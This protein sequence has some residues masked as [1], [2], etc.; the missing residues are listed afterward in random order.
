V[1]RVL[2]AVLFAVSLVTPAWAQRAPLSQGP[3]RGLPPALRDVGYDQMLGAQVPLDIQLKDETGRSVKLGDYLGQ[4]PAVLALV[5]YECPMLCTLTLNGLASAMNLIS[6]DAGREYQVITV[7]FDPRETPA[8]ATA[9]KKVY[10]ARY[11]RP[12]AAQG[13]HFL[14]GDAEQIKRLTQAVG[15]RYVWDAETKQFA[16]PAGVVTLTPEGKISHYLFGVEYAPK[17]LRLALVEA[18]EHRVGS[19]VDAVLLYCYHYDP[20]TGKYGLVVMRVVRAGGA[21]TLA[22]LASFILIMWRRD[23][24]AAAVQQ[25]RSA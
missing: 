24:K 8:L 7:S 23:K 5:Y 14:T 18:S 15:F 25:E 12:G 19:A 10:L 17:D 4:R 9:K 21:L 2:A 6:F 22:A 13:W 16:H 3:T 11:K 1:R 20:V